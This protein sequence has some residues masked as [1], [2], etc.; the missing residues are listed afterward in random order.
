VVS[1][2]PYET[3]RERLSGQGLTLFR[4]MAEAH[5]AATGERTFLY[6]SHLGGGA[7]LI[8]S[9]KPRRDWQDVDGGD[10]RD[11]ANYGLLRQTSY[12]KSP[13][14]QVTS[15]G[16][17]FHRWLM[18]QEGLPVEQEEVSTVRLVEGGGFARRHP[19]CSEHLAMAWELLRSDRID[20]QA[21][22]ALGGHLRNALFDLAAD[23]IGSG[24]AYAR[25]QP[26]EPLRRAIRGAGV[27]TREQTVLE[28]LVDLLAAVLHLDQ[29]VTHIRDESDR[30]I[31]LR[32]WAEVRRAVH[33]TVFV[34]AELDRALTI[35]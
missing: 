27:S 30:G 21:V 35:G 8:L 16:K 5:L 22:S 20:E 14:Y 18:A 31:P 23:L 28:A 7:L 24:T 15:E 29:R 1:R 12:G 10:L 34:C 26:V 4:E 19:G 25:E 2:I 9:A 6:L 32:E 33:T 13:G 11:M 17:A 3:I